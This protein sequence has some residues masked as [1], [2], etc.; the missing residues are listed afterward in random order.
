MSYLQIPAAGIRW[1]HRASTLAQQHSSPQALHQLIC[2]AP[3]R[4]LKEILAKTNICLHLLTKLMCQNLKNTGFITH[5]M[6]QIP[7]CKILF[8]K[9]AQHQAVI[10][11]TV[12]TLWLPCVKYLHA[13]KQILSK[14][15]STYFTGN[16]KTLEDHFFFQNLRQQMA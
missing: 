6:F 4:K 9:N 3:P 15:T 12:A 10:L 14:R 8:R 16:L 13:E 5:D 11:M 2:S 1:W 7:E